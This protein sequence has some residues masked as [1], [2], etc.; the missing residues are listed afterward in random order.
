MKNLTV[1]YGTPKQGILP[2]FFSECLDITDPVFTFDRFMEEIDLRKYL[3]KL[4]AHE[5]GRI[6]YNPVNMLKTVLFGFMDEGCISLR[7]LEDNC[8]VNIRY[9]YL[10]DG[11]R[12]SYRTFGYFI[13]TVLMNQA[14]SLFYEITQEIITK[15]HVDLDHLYIDGSK[16]EA[17]AN[18]Y[19]WVWKK[20]TEKLSI[21]GEN[22]NSYSKTDHSATLMRIKRDYMGNDQLL[23]TY[24][25]QVGIADEY[26]REY[27]RIVRRGI[28][29]VKMEVFLVSIGFNLYKYHRKQQA[30][31][32]MAA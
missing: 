27:G 24:N 29:S 4:P 26:I 7:K 30:Y 22:R 3:S 17:N 14:E 12:P 18:K 1:Y 8:K 21:C 11:K 25:V 6:R 2:A 32:D 13:N 5:L 15:E 23:P 20:G 16:F 28:D 9:K 19:S 10:M 31:M